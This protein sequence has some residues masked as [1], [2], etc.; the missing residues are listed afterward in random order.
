MDD[1]LRSIL[2]FLD[3]KYSVSEPSITKWS[4]IP[5]LSR[6]YKRIEKP[7]PPTLDDSITSEKWKFIQ[8]YISQRG[9]IDMGGGASHLIQEALTVL[10]SF[11]WAR[12]QCVYLQYGLRASKNTSTCMLTISLDQYVKPSVDSP[13]LSSA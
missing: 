2:P 13:G 4:S 5:A 1:R 3:K 11:L 12:S 9:I 6:V 10:G 7:T 8:F